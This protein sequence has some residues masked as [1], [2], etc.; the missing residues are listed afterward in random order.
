MRD[1][2]PLTTSDGTKLGQ[3]IVS[4][5]NANVDIPQEAS[6]KISPE[7]AILFNKAIVA[8]P[9]MVPEVCSVHVKNNEFRYRW[10]NRDGLG[11]RI[12]MQRRAQG[13]LNATDKDVE[14]L[15]GDVQSKDGEIRAGD[16]I[17]M[18]IR[19]DLYDSAIKA[20]MVRA[21]VLANA[22][23]FYTEGGSSDVMSDAS[24]SRKTVSAE[25]GHRTGMATAFIPDNADRLVEDSINSG[26][27]EETRAVVDELRAG[28]KGAKK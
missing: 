28:S 9:L 14:V 1:E 22:R 27:A 16:L 4:D 26:R 2:V 18:K 6:R 21:N 12:F 11:G 8:K 5:L 25:P 13:F 19:A 24:P 17:L 7:A 10:V 20:N 3:T 15:G 23:G